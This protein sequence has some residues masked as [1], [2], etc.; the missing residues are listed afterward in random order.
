MSTGEEGEKEATEDEA[1]TEAPEAKTAVGD[2]ARN[3]MGYSGKEEKEMKGQENNDDDRS[4]NKTVAQVMEGEE[5]DAG[6]N[7]IQEMT[8]ADST[9]DEQEVGSKTDAE[10]D[11]GENTDKKEDSKEMGKESRRGTTVFSLSSST[12][13]SQ[14]EGG[15]ATEHE[16]MSETFEDALSSPKGNDGE[17]Q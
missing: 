9:T 16:E 7:D 13:S 4:E 11:E 12:S 10:N 8:T 5:Q 15:A 17:E 1:M 3:E 6:K 14:T 2:E